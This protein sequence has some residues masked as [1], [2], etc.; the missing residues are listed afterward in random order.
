MNE[1]QLETT[2]SY[3]QLA[4][5]LTAF[6]AQRATDKSFKAA[7]DFALLEDFDHLYRYADL[8]EN[9]MGVRAE[10]LVG[11]YTGNYAGQTYDSASQTS[12]RLDKAR[13]R[14]QKKSTS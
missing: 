4:V 3:E 14:Q 12:Q 2:I 6:L 7:L 1:T 13:D 5:D 10:T 8:L 9:D 11:N